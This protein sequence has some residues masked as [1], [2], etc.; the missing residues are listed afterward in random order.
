MKLASVLR[1]L[2]GHAATYIKGVPS[3]LKSEAP[4]LAYKLLRTPAGWA[5]ISFIFVYIALIKYCSYAYYRDPTSAFFDP[6]RGYER[7]YSLHRHAQADAFIEAVGTAPPA[8]KAGK[9]PNMCIGIATVDRPEEQYVRSTVGSLMAG[10]QDTER[11]EIQLNILI[12]H[13][14]PHAHSIYGEA[15]LEKVADEVL[16]YDVDKKQAELLH[17]WEKE[18]D[19]RRKAIFDYTYTLQKCIESG[20]S[21]IAMIEDDTLA[22]AEWYAHA[23][24]ALDTA[25]AQHLAPTD[26]L[27]LRLFFTEEF[28]GWNSERWPRYLLMS[29]AL[30]LATA[31]VLFCVKT[32]LHQKPLSMTVIGVVSLICVPLCIL[33]YFLAGKLSMMPLPPGVHVMNNFG[34]CAQGFVFSREMAPAVVARL[35]E[36]GMGFVDMLLEEWANEENLVRWAVMPSLLQHIGGRSSKGDD[37][38]FFGGAAKGKRTVAEKIWSF[39]FEMYKVQDEPP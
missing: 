18:K 20:A 12:A 39:G 5:L 35:T 17:D 31:F 9:N 1:R 2:S 36:K 23:N 4:V 27:Y 38:G 11:R 13:T 30:V 14:D 21:W 15:W 6:V 24:A 7:H 22:V 32:Q 37:F 29:I 25:D 26:W 34:C 16:V 19:Y 3:R 28:L 10:L 8:V 33:L